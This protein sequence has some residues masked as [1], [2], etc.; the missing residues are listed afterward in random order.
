MLYKMGSESGIKEKTLLSESIIFIHLTPLFY[1]IIEEYVSYTKID[2][3]PTFV[4]KCTFDKLLTN[5]K[6]YNTVYI[7]LLCTKNINYS[8]SKL[9]IFIFLRLIL[10]LH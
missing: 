3:S 4:L 6:D 5:N 10:K 1:S 9:I 8:T 2:L 7:L